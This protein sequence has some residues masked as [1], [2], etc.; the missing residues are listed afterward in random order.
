MDSA[1]YIAQQVK[2][3]LDL[4]EEIDHYQPDEDMVEVLIGLVGVWGAIEAQLIFP[5]LEVAFEGTE[6]VLQASRSRLNTLYALQGTIHDGEGAVGPFSDLAR[7]YI[8]G[9]KYHLAADIQEIA[10]LAAQLPADVSADLARSMA[11]M[12][13]DLE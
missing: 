1:A 2:A 11:A 8:D 13:Q 9:V 5:T 7:K 6:A 10:P 12:K 3:L 4:I